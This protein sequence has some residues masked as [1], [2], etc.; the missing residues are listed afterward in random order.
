MEIVKSKELSGKI[1]IYHPYVS[2]RG[3]LLIKEMLKQ[4]FIPDNKSEVF[5]ETPC[6]MCGVQRSKH[7]EYMKTGSLKGFRKLNDEDLHGYMPLRC[8]IAHGSIDRNI[9]TQE[10]NRFNSPD[11]Y[12]GKY[13]YITIGS[14]VIMEGFDYKGL[15]HIY[16][17][18]HTT[19]ISELIQVIGRG[20]RHGS[21]EQLPINLRNVRIYLLTS[22]IPGKQSHEEYR[23]I[24]KMIDHIE[25]QKIEREINAEAIDS[26]IHFSTTRSDKDDLI[27]LTFKPAYKIPNYKLQDLEL[28]HFYAFH[29]N[30]E[31]RLIKHIIKRLFY[32]RSRL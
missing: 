16:V 23:Y 27:S 22:T 14:D 15:R 18:T 17:V 3:V 32:K 9:I 1:L 2:L 31:V 11:N 20:A 12:D 25:I 21:H 6:A 29:A 4:N 24:K 10:R 19:N 5:D 13:L 28:S 30:D 8:I 26:D 7:D